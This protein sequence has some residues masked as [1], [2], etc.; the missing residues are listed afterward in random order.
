[1]YMGHKCFISFKY[2]DFEFKKYIQEDLDVDMIDKSLNEKI[3]SDDFDV[4]MKK[5]R[6]GYLSDSTV[7]IFIIGENSNELLGTDEQKYIKQELQSS[8]FHGVNNTKNGVL[9]IVLPK[10]YDKIYTGSGNCSKCGKSHNYVNIN[11]NT[12]IEEFRYNYYIP[13][14]KC[15]WSESDRYCVL[16]KWDDFKLNPNLFID[17]AFDKRDSEISSKTKVRF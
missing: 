10:M 7:T 2:E 6:A 17:R 3:D 4:V 14:N 15:A 9:G 1:M 12:V 11:K 8:L 16:V 5:I 13:N